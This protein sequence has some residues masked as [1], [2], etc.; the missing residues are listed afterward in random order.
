MQSENVKEYEL[1]RAEMITVK[2]C[3]TKYIG[4][5]LAG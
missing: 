5:V 3:I 2:D 4:F 1:V